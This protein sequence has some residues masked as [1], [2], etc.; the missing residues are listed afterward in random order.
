MAAPVMSTFYAGQRLRAADMN[1][2]V[3]DGVDWAIEGKCCK[4][5]RTTNQTIANTTLTA[6]VFDDD[7]F[8]SL[9]WHG[10]NSSLITP[11]YPG[12][13][14]IDAC[15][16]WVFNGNGIRDIYIFGA[17]TVIGFAAFMPDMSGGGTHTP[18]NVSTLVKLDGS[19]SVSCW[20]WQN[21]GAGLATDV[22]IIQSSL[23]VQFVGT[24]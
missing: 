6:M 21:S 5:K 15:V 13:Y 11:T 3:R 18:C 24:Y 7:Q 20:V 19:T 2:Q 23:S 8:D 4:A 12:Y 14:R 9:G 17:S 1:S 16:D 22:S 10:A